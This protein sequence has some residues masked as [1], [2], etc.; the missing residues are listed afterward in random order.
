MEQIVSMLNS[1]ADVLRAGLTF[2]GNYAGSSLAAQLITVLKISSGL[3]SFFLFAAIVWL[4]FRFNKL[5]GTSPMERLTEA[6]RASPVQPSRYAKHWI[7]IKSRLQRP[8]E[9]EWKL[10]VIEADK[11]CDS[12]LRHM[13]YLGQTMGERLRTIKPAQLQSL[14]H[15]WEAHKVRNTIVHD[16]Q[17]YLSEYEAKQAIVRYE[18]FL[19]EMQI[20]Q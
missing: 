3:A 2:A 14:E 4:V 8:S 10:A 9:A 20:I 5:M 19:K 1:L 17:F 13:G 15:L 18:E 12:I 16:P 6:M 7:K 11:L